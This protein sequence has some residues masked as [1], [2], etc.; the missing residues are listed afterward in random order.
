MAASD[1]PRWAL[2]WSSNDKQW[3]LYDCVSS[4]PKKLCDATVDELQIALAYESWFLEKHGDYEN[5]CL[6]ILYAELARRLP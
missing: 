1:E 4:S 6:E 3:E 5:E 2:M